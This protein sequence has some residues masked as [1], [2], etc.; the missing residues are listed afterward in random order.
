MRCCRR[1]RPAHLG[2]AACARHP[3]L[4]EAEGAADLVLLRLDLGG[5]YVL[6]PILLVLDPVTAPKHVDSH[7]GAR[8][9]AAS[10]VC[11]GISV[12]CDEPITRSRGYDA[13]M[14]Q[15]HY[16]AVRLSCSGW[17][18]I[19]FM[20]SQE[21]MSSPQCFQRPGASGHHS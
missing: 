1:G 14:I 13:V 3:A 19:G 16:E 21:G 4:Q 18:L 10:D 2:L 15:I 5:D 12:Y 8:R 9:A 6:V 7:R 17:L 11:L 20:R